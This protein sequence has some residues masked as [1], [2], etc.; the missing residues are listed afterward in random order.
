[1]LELVLIAVAT[2]IVSRRAKT[3]GHNP[4]I[5]GML[6]VLTALV[7][8]FIGGNYFGL[9]GNLLGVLLE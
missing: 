1:M 5:F 2:G 4:V 8:G 3:N 9:A 7:C 6:T